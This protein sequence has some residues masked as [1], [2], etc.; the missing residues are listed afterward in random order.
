MFTTD[1]IIFRCEFSWGFFNP[2][3]ANPTKWSNTLK[4]FVDNLPTN[5]LSV[6]DNFAGLARKRLTLEN[7]PNRFQ[8]LTPKRQHVHGIK[9]SH[10][11]PLL[12]HIPSK[13]LPVQ[14]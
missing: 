3:S 14:S 2:L 6:F 10:A 11:T 12:K 4:Q 1:R 9:V 8:V 13:H 7:F 5:C